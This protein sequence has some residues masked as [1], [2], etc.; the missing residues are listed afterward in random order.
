MSDT[1]ELEGVVEDC[2][3]HRSNTITFKVNDQLYFVDTAEYA[4]IPLMN[5]LYVTGIAKE[6]G[7]IPEGIL[8]VTEMDLFDQKDNNLL[9]SLTSRC[10]LRD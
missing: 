4:P 7:F 6:G 10:Y 8:K 5:Q 1:V 3:Y 9:A 2:R